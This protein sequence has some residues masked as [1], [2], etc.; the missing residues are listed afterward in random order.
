MR[1]CVISVEEFISS[2]ANKMNLLKSKLCCHL[3]WSLWLSPIS[4]ITALPNMLENLTDLSCPRM[5]TM[6]S[7]SAPYPSNLFG[8]A[9]IYEESISTFC[10]CIKLILWSW[11]TWASQ[12]FLHLA[13]PLSEAHCPGMSWIP[14]QEPRCPAPKF[15]HISYLPAEDFCPFDVV[16]IWFWKRQTSFLTIQSSISLS[17]SCSSGLQSVTTVRTRSSKSFTCCKVV[18]QVLCCSSEKWKW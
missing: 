12:P 10:F 8:W 6:S 9:L 2:K 3:I 15:W 4:P 14:L 5:R 7:C 17:L 13:N 16:V 1:Q 18:H 11:P